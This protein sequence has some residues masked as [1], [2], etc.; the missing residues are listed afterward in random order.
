MRQRVLIVPS[1]LA[2]AATAQAAQPAL[3]P[4][5]EPLVGP[6]MIVPG[7]F[8][9]APP[10]YVADADDGEG[11]EVS[12]IIDLMGSVAN[13]HLYGLAVIGCTNGTD[14]AGDESGQWQYWDGSAWANL[15]YW[16]NWV[17][18]AL[19]ADPGNSN[20]YTGNE[21]ELGSLY[22]PNT[23]GDANNDDCAGVL[24]RRGGQALRYVRYPD[25]A[26][27]FPG[28]A[29]LVGA[30][31]RLRLWYNGPNSG[32]DDIADYEP[33]TPSDAFWR[34]AN[35]LWAIA[36]S[37]QNMSAQVVTLTLNTAPRLS[38]GAGSRSVQ[39]RT[40][41]GVPQELNVGDLLAGYVE[42]SE[43]DDAAIGALAYD[44]TAYFADNQPT[45]VWQYRRYNTATWVDVP[46]GARISGAGAVALRSIDD[47]RYTGTMPLT[48]N[49]DVNYPAL[50]LRPW[51]GRP[52]TLE[53]NRPAITYRAMTNETIDDREEAYLGFSSGQFSDDR[54]IVTSIAGPSDY[55]QIA[56]YGG[57]S[58]GG[59][60]TLGGTGIPQSGTSNI[61]YY[62]LGPATSDGVER[63][64]TV[65]ASYPRT[66]LA[67]YTWDAAT[68]GYVALP[69][70]PTG[71][72]D[73]HDGVFIATRV[74]LTLN[75]SG[76]TQ[77]PPDLIPLRPGQNFIAQPVLN[78]SGT[79]TT[80][81]PWSSFELIDSD[82]STV[83]TGTPRTE[84]IGRVGSG[85][86]ATERPWL[87]NGSSYQR[88][89]TIDSTRGYWVRNNT[90][91]T[92]YLRRDPDVESIQNQQVQAAAATVDDLPPPPPVGTAPAAAEAGSQGCGG[93]SGV[94]GLVVLALGLLGLRRLRRR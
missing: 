10:Y 86:P 85:D 47:V 33:A 8:P 5:A 89:D 67:A 12:E 57:A 87:W 51:D 28:G 56:V 35:N 26:N 55:L 32:D 83:I 70:E 6:G 14:A 48:A 69:A 79:A 2:L 29:D 52:V 44:A 93:G 77:D 65:V 13:Q 20:N 31:V 4:A 59:S 63:I 53:N 7:D 68:Q 58:A 37:D 73:V 17:D 41:Q 78:I 39:G 92:L 3:T 84:A 34:Q 16:R 54:R 46:S 50:T 88:A 22:N 21:Y 74:Q 11:Y 27:D 76:T 19:E 9:N 81:H 25:A 90:A 64:R 36:H 30:T 94:A 91:R 45:G 23:S 43:Q 18:R 62:A 75:L 24:I 1:L 60:V 82:Q 40:Q 66:L 71:G 38:S 80:T 42:D 61:I 15:S 49:E 72:F